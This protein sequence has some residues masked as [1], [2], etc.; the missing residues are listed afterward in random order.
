MRE[1]NAEKT[2]GLAW[3]VLNN[4]CPRCRTGKLFTHSNPYKLSTTMR[5]PDNCPVCGQDFNIQTGF[6]FGTGFVSYAISVALLMVGFVLWYLAF[7]ISTKDNSI[8]WWL[9]VNIAVLV[10]LQPLLQR[11]ARSIWIAFFVRYEGPGT[12]DKAK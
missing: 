12:M 1:T 8:F 11:L 5:M 3:S 10:V 4:R 6:Y 2:P 7:G 9:G